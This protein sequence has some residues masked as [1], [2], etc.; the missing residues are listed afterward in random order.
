MNECRL[1]G[2]DAGK[3][4][5]ACHTCATTAQADLR[6]IAG[7]A[8]HLDG[9][10]ARRRSNWTSGTIGRTATLPLPYDP[11]VSKVADPILIALHGTARIVGDATSTWPPDDSLAGTARWLVTWCEWLRR[12]DVGPDEFESFETHKAALI[13]LFDN[14]PETHYAGP[15]GR[16]IDD[17]PPC[18]QDLY[19]EVGL[20]ALI[21]PSCNT[22]H[23]IEPRQEQLDAS[24]ADYLGTAKEISNLCR[25]QFGDDVS[26]AMIRGYVRHGLIQSKGTRMEHTKTGERQANLFRI[27]DVREA[28]KNLIRDEKRRRSLRRDAAHHDRVP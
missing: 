22:L 23:A 8:H 3:D 15:C 25:F 13:Q 10:R 28:V 20:T 11:R 18:T 4:H 5:F 19:I 9:K 21:C 6:T 24:V 17:G 16:L 27:G 12:R 2:R 14:P 1:C 7:L 26:T